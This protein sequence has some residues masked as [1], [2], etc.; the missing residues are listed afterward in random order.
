MQQVTESGVTKS[1][2]VVIIMAVTITAMAQAAKDEATPPMLKNG[3]PFLKFIR[4]P[5]GEQPNTF[6]IV[7]LKFKISARGNLDT[8]NISD[9]ASVEFVSSIQKQLTLLNG[10][11]KLNYL[12][13]HSVASKWVIIRFY[14]AGYREDSGDCLIRQEAE[15]IA[16]YEREADLFECSVNLDH[17]RKCS[18]DYLEGYDYFLYPPWLS[19]AER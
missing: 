5:Q 12:N 19:R 3:E 4:L 7:T 13:G 9:N 15:F 10:Q 18:T 11:W 1:L 17:L 16:S 8:L 14:V 2:L 6:K